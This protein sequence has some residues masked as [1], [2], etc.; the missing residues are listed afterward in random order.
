MTPAC[1]LWHRG[2]G[3]AACHL[4]FGVIGT[5]LHAVLFPPAG[6]LLGRF[7]PT[8]FPSSA[9]IGSCR[10]CAG[11]SPEC[12]HIWIITNHRFACVGAAFYTH[13]TKPLSSVYSHVFNYSQYLT[14]AG[15]SETNKDVETA[16]EQNQR[17]GHLCCVTCHVGDRN[18]S[19][20]EPFL[21]SA[22]LHTV[23]A[24]CEVNCIMRCS[25]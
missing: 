1:F 24:L 20:K 22:H 4:R 14:V 3:T 2:E 23:L 8:A 9:V 17:Q 11:C 18:K 16:E 19:Y 12:G 5:G 10:L 25:V 6:F 21:N 13:F 7:Y 15:Q